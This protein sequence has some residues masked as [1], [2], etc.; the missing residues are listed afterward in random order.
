MQSVA[1][2]QDATCRS[3]PQDVAMEMAVVP[4]DLRGACLVNLM[5]ALTTDSPS[6]CVLF[7]F[8]F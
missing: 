6:G 3:F 7:I 8:V 2:Y 1:K 5:V 4:W